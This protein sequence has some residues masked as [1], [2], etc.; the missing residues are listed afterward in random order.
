[1]AGEDGFTLVEIVIAMLLLAVTMVGVS[2]LIYTGL[3]AGE[4]AGNQTVALNLAQ[5]IIDEL[6]ENPAAAADQP[7]TSFAARPGFEDYAAYAYQVQV[8]FH[9]QRLNRVTVLVFYPVRDK[10]R[11]VTLS[12]LVAKP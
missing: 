9:N 5:G 6:Q 10:E 11:L 1:M 12:T 8:A 3:L 4:R 2:G 7:K